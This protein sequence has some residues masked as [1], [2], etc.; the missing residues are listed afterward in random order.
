MAFLKELRATSKISQDQTFGPIDHMPAAS[1]KTASSK[2]AVPLPSKRTGRWAIN[3]LAAKTD[4]S[5]LK[6]QN[7][8]QLTQKARALLIQSKQQEPLHQKLRLGFVR[9]KNARLAREQAARDQAQA[10]VDEQL[11]Q[12]ED[13][14]QKAL[15]E[16]LRVQK[17]AADKKAAQQR[18]EEE[19]KRLA[20]EE[21]RAAEEA[22]R[23]A[24]KQIFRHGGIIVAPSTDMDEALDAKMAVRNHS[25][26]VVATTVTNTT[27]D[28]DDVARV[29]GTAIG[30]RA[31]AW[32][33]D[34]SV[35]AWMQVLCAAMNEG[36]GWKKDRS[37]PTPPF[38]AY[39]SAWLKQLQEKGAASLKRWTSRL[40]IKDGHV[41]EVEYLFLP[42]NTGAHWT[43]VIVHGP[44]RTIEYLDSFGGS[45]SGAVAA[46]R[47]LLEAELGNA[48]DADEWT[49]SRNRS[50]HQD[51]SDDCGVFTCF[52]AFAA[53]RGVSYREVTAAKM[54]AARRL[55]AAV[56]MNGGF[57]GDAKL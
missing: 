1:G 56:L 38:A 7:I 3:L 33:N 30:S 48:Y 52:N 20:L 42:V 2:D 18:A 44:S 40:G 31:P 17:E 43:L 27:L 14:R 46:V 15:V 29:L 36:R 23:Q 28:R 19:R 39:S 51:N 25:G 6:D 55:M 11:A 13:A 50:S 4:D 35:N 41:D 16:K 5:A 21:A 53:A 24:A 57:V 8:E 9:S 22:E 37:A 10:R 47:S 26:A 34:V 32:L 49:I 12:L 54:P 45:G